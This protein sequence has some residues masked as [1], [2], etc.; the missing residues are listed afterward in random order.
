MEKAAEK[1][2]KFDPFCRECGG[3][4]FPGFVFWGACWGVPYR[5]QKSGRVLPSGVTFD[6]GAAT[7]I[8]FRKFAPQILGFRDDKVWIVLEILNALGSRDV[9]VLDCTGDVGHFG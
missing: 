5:D 2:P 6:E 1:N 4:N 8:F 9:K 7:R 3:P